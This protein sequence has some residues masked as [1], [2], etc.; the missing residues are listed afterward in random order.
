MEFEWDEAKR[1]ENHRKH[2]LDFRDAAK[3]FQGFTLTVENDR[4]NYGETRLITLG[5]LEDIVVVMVH[6]FRGDNLRLISMR[7][8]KAKERRVYEE[9]ILFRS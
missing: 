7:K 6:T 8:A 5:K 9:K 2:G 4:Q 3:V 1:R